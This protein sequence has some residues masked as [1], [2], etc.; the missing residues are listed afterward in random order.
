MQGHSKGQ[1]V[2][3]SIGDWKTIPKTKINHYR[4]K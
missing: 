4:E 1:A 3:A 2:P